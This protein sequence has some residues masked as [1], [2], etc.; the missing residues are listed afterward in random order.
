MRSHLT[1]GAVLVLL[2]VSG[3]WSPAFRS[4]AAQE[5]PL[6]WPGLPR[7]SDTTPALSWA[8]ERADHDYVPDPPYDDSGARHVRLPKTVRHAIHNLALPEIR[9]EWRMERAESRMLSRRTPTGSDPIHEWPE[10]VLRRADHYGPVFQIPFPR[11]KHLH[12]YVFRLRTVM[13]FF[14]MVILVHDSRTDRV[15]TTPVRFSTRWMAKRPHGSLVQPPLIHFDDLDQDGRLEVVYQK[16][17]HN[18]TMVNSVVYHYLAVA[19]DLS[20][21]EIFQRETR[22]VD[23]YARWDEEREG[24]INREIDKLGPGKIRLRVLLVDH[25]PDTTGREAGRM[26]YEQRRPGEPFR[27]TSRTVD[28]PR[29]EKLLV[30][31]CGR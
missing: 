3:I 20:F 9:R 12:L 30:N 22:L 1:R 29:Y 23:L 27:E 24:Y 15:T 17:E 7:M 26:T 13:S 28:I 16:R 5:G 18:G 8:I 11:P 2:G 25:P 19:K 14:D 21:R 6:V 4:G 31:I 10:D